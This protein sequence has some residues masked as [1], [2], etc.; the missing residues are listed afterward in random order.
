M[1]IN[2]R[3]PTDP[4]MEA[5]AAALRPYTDE[6][7]SAEVEIFRYSP[8]SIRVRVIDPDFRGK[9]RSQRHHTVWPLL[10][11]LDE[12]VLGELT[13]L[14]LITPEERTSSMANR[15][16]EGPTFAESFPDAFKPARGSSAAIP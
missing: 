10:Y 5:F 11:P 9:S 3:G 7:R 16:F 4:Y 1:A 8:V 13:M 15:D 14:L 12:E 6:H 2:V